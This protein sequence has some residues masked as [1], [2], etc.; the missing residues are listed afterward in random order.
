MTQPRSV[1]VAVA[2]PVDAPPPATVDFGA[3]VTEV[4]A[5]HGGVWTPEA[6]AELQARLGDNAGFGRGGGSSGG[7]GGGRAADV[8]ERTSGVAASAMAGHR[9]G[10]E[11]AGAAA[12]QIS[13]ASGL[14]ALAAVGAAAALQRVQAAE[15]AAVPPGAP[16]LVPKKPVSK[17][18]KTRGSG[19]NS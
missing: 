14:D 15:A 1:F 10:D 6:A 5:A 4:M 12:G 2:P 13:R 16:P 7:G 8:E 18:M 9:V 3:I 17:R 11:A 19:D